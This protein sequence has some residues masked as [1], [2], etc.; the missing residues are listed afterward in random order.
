MTILLG[1]QCLALIVIPAIIKVTEPLG[2]IVAICVV[3]VAVAFYVELM[4]QPL[5]MPHARGAAV[6]VRG[7][8]TVLVIGMIAVIVST[9]G[10][11]GS[12]AV[13]LGLAAES[14]LVGLSAPFTVWA[15]FGTALYLWLFRHG[16][17]TR[18]AA[19]WVVVVASA[20]FLWEGLTR[21]ILGQ[22][23]ALIL[24]V[25]VMSVFAKLFRLRVIIVIL[26]LIPVLW[27][28][29]YD[30]RDSVRRAI[31]GGPAS[32]SANAPLERLQ[33]DTQMANIAS[34]VPR[35][36]G[37]EALD[38]LTLIRIGVIPGFLD[39]ARPS[40]DTGSRMSVALGGAPTNSQSATMLGNVF[41]F[42]G[43]VGIG[44]LAAVLALTMGF[45]LRR[46]NPWAL[47]T[48]GLVYWH[49]M[50]FNSAYPDVVPRILQGLVSMGVA[51]VLVRVLSRERQ[52]QRTVRRVLRRP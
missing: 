50:S 42:E 23:A 1:V 18:T 6:S 17:V 19:T 44:L 29:I 45:L 20:L 8:A 39:P 52:R 15:L 12:Y 26:L 40:V 37:L 33:L 21:A 38:L 28:P 9:L 27:P 31:S 32:V 5:A 30:L 3:A 14:P 48:V 51:Y 36:T 34:L 47:A 4:M 10:G 41:I 24:T 43:W 46:D 25:L 35:P 49:A 16:R 7:S 22:S 2:L 13:Q 11:Q